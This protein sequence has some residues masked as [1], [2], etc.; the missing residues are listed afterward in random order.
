MPE[1]RTIHGYSLGMLGTKR[2]PYTWWE[3]AFGHRAMGSPD[4]PPHPQC[5]RCVYDATTR[6]QLLGGT[7]WRPADSAAARRA[8]VEALDGKPDLIARHDEY[9]RQ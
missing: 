7:H 1:Q 2:E 5:H 8:T 6:E 4:A 9:G 3:C